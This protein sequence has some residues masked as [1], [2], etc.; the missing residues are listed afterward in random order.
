MKRVNWHILL[1]KDLLHVWEFFV[2]AIHMNVQRMAT[3]IAPGVAIEKGRDGYLLASDLKQQYMRGSSAW[4]ST[5]QQM[6]GSYSDLPFIGVVAY[7]RKMKVEIKSIAKAMISVERIRE[8]IEVVSV[9]HAYHCKWT[10]SQ[11][12]GWMFDDIKKHYGAQLCLKEHGLWSCKH[13]MRSLLGRR[14]TEYDRKQLL[15]LNAGFETKVFRR[16]SRRALLA[17]PI[18][19]RYLRRLEYL[20]FSEVFYMIKRFNR[21][22]RPLTQAEWNWT[23]GLLNSR[24]FERPLYLQAIRDLVRDTKELTALVRAAKKIHQWNRHTKPAEIREALRGQIIDYLVDNPNAN[25]TLPLVQLYELTR[26]WHEELNQRRELL[27]TGVHDEQPLAVPNIEL[28][29]V[30]DAS[31]ELITTAGRLREEGQLMHHCVGGY[32][33]QGVNAES[34][35]FHVEYQETKATVQVNHRG[36]VVQSLGPCN[37]TNPASEW[38]QNILTQW[39]QKLCTA[40]P[41]EAVDLIVNPQG[42]LEEEELAF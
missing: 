21:L 25:T 40:L 31:I 42:Q 38:G 15:K 10:I 19:Q 17:L 13:W 12:I 33:N 39:G 26:V 16:Y 27:R 29:T 23:V 1:Q 7:L 5:Y 24:I 41:V 4:F 32:V 6:G 28:P 8:R 37:Q 34:F 35:F 14:P 3:R 9:Y 36:Q 20:S 2:S 18:E 22:N 11:Y 30:K